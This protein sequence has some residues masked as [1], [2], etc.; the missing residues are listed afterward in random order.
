MPLFRGQLK[1]IRG[2]TDYK[3]SVLVASTNNVG[4]TSTISSV[5]GV[6]LSEGDR[7]LLVGQTTTTENGI[8]AS[9]SN[10]TIARAFDA[11]STEEFS[12]GMTVYVEQ[13]TSNGKSTWLL[14]TTGEIV[15]GTT[16]LQ[17]QKQSQI[18]DSLEGT[19]GG[20]SKSLTLGVQ[21]NG[22]ITTVTENT[23]DSD[24]VTEGSSNLYH[25]TARARAS[26]S[27]S[28]SNLSYNSSTG[29]MSF[30]SASLTP[31]TGITGDNF[32]TSTNKT[33]AIDTSVIPTLSSGVSVFTNDAGYITGYTVTES[34]VTTHQAALSITESQISDL[35][36]YITASSTDTLT[37]KTIGASTISGNLIPDT[38]ETYDLG[39]STYRFN[40]LYLAGSTIDLGGAKLTNDG[41]DNLDIK[42]SSGNR[43]I[44][45]ASAIELVDSS[46]KKIK[47][48]RDATSGK[49]KSRKFDSSGNAEADGDDVNEISEDKTPQL[50]GTLDANGN[51]IDMGS[52]NITDTKVGQWD[53]S[54][55]WGNHASSNYL[56]DYTVTESDVTGHQSALSITESQISDLD[57]YLPITLSTVVD[58]RVDVDSISQIRF[59]LDETTSGS[60]GNVSNTSSYNIALSVSPNVTIG[61]DTSGIFY[62]SDSNR[63]TYEDIILRTNGT[64][65]SA[66]G[67]A[68]PSGATS[69]FGFRGNSSTTGYRS[70]TTASLNTSS[71]TKLG[72]DIIQGTGSN[73]GEGT[74]STD[75][76]KIY[77]STNGGS[78][79]TLM[80]TY[81]GS[82]R[83]YDTWTTV[84][85]SLP[86]GAIG[87]SV[88]FKFENIH[89]NTGDFDHWAIS[90]VN[91]NTIETS[92]PYFRLDVGSGT[93]IDSLEN[94]TTFTGNLVGDV[95]GNVIGAVTGTSGSFSSNLQSNGN[96]YANGSYTYLANSTNDRVYIRT[97]LLYFN[98]VLIT[99]TGTE[100]N[101]VDGVTSNVQTQLDTK[102][103]LTG[104]ETL[105]NKSIDGGSF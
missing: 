98:N 69:I 2:L 57:D 7:I 44:I 96:F 16:S 28:G 21:K 66:N 97:P 30:T 20:A 73:G 8:Y 76:F 5:D 40:D 90:K 72:F 102:A 88:K 25:T 71:Y 43:K 62:I 55:G 84:A 101:Y 81:Y 31:G 75:D 78:S 89:T 93:V 34:D 68:N 18:Y 54:Y 4:V 103:S 47:I 59:I 60:Q 99:A 61:Y 86:S 14:I 56:T 24:N 33:F 82:P 77:Y 94:S 19:Y 17:F 48:E 13:G 85:I 49:M 22:V 80:Q 51:Y 100:L 26:I 11:D 58:G 87:S 1:H 95:T 23:L 12:S 70:L 37:N 39:S 91:L 35:S 53:T 38:T 79:Y 36:S 3:D 32:D 63:G 64:G 42:D 6:T 65:T 46:G 83:A 29:S 104:V 9:Q 105:D 74:D 41:S 10:G 15:L 67:F 27:A 50:G 45:R 52:N 92:V